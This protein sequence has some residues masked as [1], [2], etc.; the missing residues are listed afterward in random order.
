[1]ETGYIALTLRVEAAP[2]GGYVSR[3]PELEIA[4]QGESIDE[5]LASIKEAVSTLLDTLSEMG[6]AD[7]F[8]LS[9][10]IKLERDPPSQ[11]QPHVHTGEVV[12]VLAALIGS[13]A[14]LA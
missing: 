11:A 4:S 5:A 3:C 9:H 12:A 10:K 8:F 2:E 6:E 13:K 1:M 7:S 14:T